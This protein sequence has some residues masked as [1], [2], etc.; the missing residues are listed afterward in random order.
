VTEALHP[1][2]APEQ[3]LLC[4]T[5][6]R[7]WVTTPGRT[8]LECPSC[9]FAW[10]A[11][12]VKRGPGGRS[13]Y[14]DSSPVF[15]DAHQAD[16]YRDETAAEAARSKLTWV[17]QH[18]APG[19]RLLDVGANL[20]LFVR[21]AA[22]HYDATGVEPSPTVVQWVRREIGARLEVGSVYDD[23]GRFD[24]QFEVVTLFDVIEHLSDPVRAIQQC[25]RFLRPGGLLFVTTPDM[26]SVMSRVLGRH[27]YY[28]DMDE[29]IALFTRRN[30]ETL[31]TRA[32]F[33]MLAARTIGRSYRFSY[34]RRR[35]QFLG[36]EA[37]IMRAAHAATWPL[38]LWPNARV[39][40]DLGD[41]MGL[42]A[43]RT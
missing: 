4:G 5:N 6:G 10:I 7:S 41:V 39:R 30:L 2:P 12:G 1:T 28:I 9:R 21:E 16:Y 37:L 15:F 34:I 27:W 18:A 25:R 36:R 23:D 22:R 33:E 38:G 40:I 8:L 14:E 31:L 26:G 32:G 17:M 11:E 3:C 43:R 20:G 35:L 19:G 13:I 24:G 42:V 29:H